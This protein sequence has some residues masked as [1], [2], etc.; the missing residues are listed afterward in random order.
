MTH[1]EFNIL[2]END[3]YKT[4]WDKGTH[5]EYRFLVG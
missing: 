3:E 4:T 5:I 2:D 1:Y